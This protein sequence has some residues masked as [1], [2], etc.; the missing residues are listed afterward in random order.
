MHIASVVLPRTSARRVL[1]RLV[2]NTLIFRRVINETLR[3]FP[4]VT[5]FPK[6]CAKTTTLS[7]AAARSS[8]TRVSVPIPEGST[9]LI[10]VPGLHYNGKSHSTCPHTSGSRK[11]TEKYWREPSKW[12]PDRYLTEWN[13]DAFVPF[14]VGARACI[15]RKSASLVQSTCSPNLTL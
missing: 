8:E 3:M 10:D 5:A 15:G 6:Y 1:H 13:A 4:P 7:C 12:S 11:K 9:V 2:V 14:S